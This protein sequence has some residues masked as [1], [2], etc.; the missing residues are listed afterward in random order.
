MTTLRYKKGVCATIYFS[1]HMLTQLETVPFIACVSFPKSKGI[2]Y[3]S[4]ENLLAQ[5][6]CLQGAYV[7]LH[8]QSLFC[9]RSTCRNIRAVSTLCRNKVFY[10][11][12]PTRIPARRPMRQWKLGEGLEA[13]KPIRPS[14]RFGYCISLAPCLYPLDR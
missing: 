12:W 13:Q 8:E 2:R 9:T 6:L 4:T 11:P 10:L 1:S 14:R 7:Q 5:Q 3:T